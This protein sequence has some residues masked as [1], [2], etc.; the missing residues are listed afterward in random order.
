MKET[1]FGTTAL[2][3]MGL[4]AQ[5]ASAASALQL[6]MTGFYRGAAGLI[7]GGKSAGPFT[8]ASGGTGGA[9]NFGRSSGG[10]RSEIRINFTGQT[11]LDNG[12]T[13][14]ALVGLN[15]SNLIAVDSTD[16]PTYN[17][18]VDFKGQYGDLRFGEFD[19]A[20]KEACVFDPGNYTWNFGINS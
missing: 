3:A 1:L 18:Y 19:S 16:T 7:I 5:S 4:A 15:G 2:V 17:S 9:G 13:V 8:T 20:V 11:T 12:L 10:F 6:G 14:S